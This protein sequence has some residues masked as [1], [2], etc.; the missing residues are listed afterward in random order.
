MQTLPGDADPLEGEIGKVG[1]FPVH[2]SVVAAAHESVKLER[3]CRYIAHPEISEQRLSIS[4]QDRVR[5]QLK[6]PWKNGTTHVEFE[7]IDFIAKL[8]VLVP[9]RAHLTRCHRILVPNAAPRP[10]RHRP[11]HPRLL[12]SH[13]LALSTG[14]PISQRL[15]KEAQASCLTEASWRPLSGG[16]FNL[17]DIRASDKRK[18]NVITM[19][20]QARWQVSATMGG[21]VQAACQRA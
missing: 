19:L 12:Q 13:T 14:L 21:P 4:P 3:L 8:A 1:G 7:P 2:A 10:H 20:D 16:R 18:R 11:L 5:Y 6:T 17:G 15:C 9:P